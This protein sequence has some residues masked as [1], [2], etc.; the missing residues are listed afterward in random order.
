MCRQR[1]VLKLTSNWIEIEAGN[2]PAPYFRGN[3]DGLAVTPLQAPTLANHFAQPDVAQ[4]MMLEALHRSPGGL[5]KLV[6]M[7]KKG[8]ICP[9]A[10]FWTQ[11]E[12]EPGNPENEMVGTRSPMIVGYAS[13]EYVDPVRLFATG[14]AGSGLLTRAAYDRMI[15]EL[16]ADYRANRYN[17]KLVPFKEVKVNAVQIPFI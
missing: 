17:P 11:T 10:I 15:A 13:L 7:V 4:R 9:A 3:S 14:G 8:P 1:N 6:R 5:F 12:V 2:E 16:R